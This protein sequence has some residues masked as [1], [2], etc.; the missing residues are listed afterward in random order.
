MGWTATPG[1]EHIQRAAHGR[2]DDWLAEISKDR[3]FGRL[4]TPDEVARAILFLGSDESAIVTGSI[5]DFDQ[6]VIG[7]YD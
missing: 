6:L 4:L 5:V 1:E 3:P 2:G 7:A